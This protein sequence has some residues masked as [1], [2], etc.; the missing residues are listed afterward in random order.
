MKKSIAIVGNGFVGGSLTTVF[1]ERS[2][3]VYAYDKAGRYVEAAR[4]FVEY[5]RRREIIVGAQLE[6]YIDYRYPNS[7]KELIEESEKI[8]GFTNIYFVCLPTPMLPSGECDT[9]IVEGVLKELM[10]VG[11][12]K[13]AVIKSTV[14]PSSTEKWNKK[15]KGTNLKIVFS[16]EFL[17]ETTALEDMRHQDRIILGGPKQAV[18]KVRD[19]FRFVFTD[20]PIHKTSSTNAEMVKYL[21]NC[22]LATKVSFANEVYQIVDRLYDQGSDIDYDRIIELATLDK[23]LGESHWKV[24][25]AMPADDGS[26]KLLKGFGGSCFCKDLNALIKVAKDLD[27]EPKVMAGAW[28]K[29]LEVRPDRDWLNLV[30]RAVSN[31]KETK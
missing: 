14:P 3:D 27:I 8:E 10:E 15:Y 9:S 28:L 21:T 18:N 6:K 7:I 11:G 24:P 26:G 12:E 5:R 25:G 19:L 20:V 31:K 29:N 30:G 2:V 22:F 1:S 17:R 23:R 4:P 16:P 13:I